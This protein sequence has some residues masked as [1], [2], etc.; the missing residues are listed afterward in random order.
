M[1]TLWLEFAGS[2]QEVSRRLTF[3]RSADLSLDEQ[4][5]FMH[6]IAGQIEPENNAWWLR[7]VGASTRL[8]VF[9]ENG[10]RIELPPGTE[11]VLP[12]PAGSISF[13]AGPT[14]YQL[15]YRTDGR[16][17]P[18]PELAPEGDATADFGTNLTERETIY[19]TTFALRRLRG[20]S[21]GLLS[22]ADVASLWGVSEKTVDNTLQRVRGRL[23]SAGVR[24]TETLEG[25]IGHLLAHGRIGLGTL[26]DIETRHPGTL[27]P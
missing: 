26:I 13:I 10:A 18:A 15:T 27:P 25:L 8:L 1:T 7:N 11:T 4:N 22:Y 5:R 14:P 17:G 16:P 9:G 19:L 12:A 6:R 2:V 3:G 23:K 20:V 21:A 24:N